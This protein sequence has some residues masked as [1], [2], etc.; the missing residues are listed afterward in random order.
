[1][2][3]TCKEGIVI[4]LGDFYTYI[5]QAA[6]SMSL[7]IQT[8]KVVKNDTKF[9]LR[10]CSRHIN[11]QLF[12]F[13]FFIKRFYYKFHFIIL[14]FENC[15]PAATNTTEMCNDVPSLTKTLTQS[16]VTVDAVMCVCV[17]V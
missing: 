15:Q 6:P 11:L 5:C 16:N 10:E 8:A 2:L 14:L 4:G 9:H 3:C 12:F 13:F 1:M 17:C 7:L